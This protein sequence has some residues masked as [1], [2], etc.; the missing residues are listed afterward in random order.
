LRWTAPGLRIP[1]AASGLDGLIPVTIAAVQE[2]D[3]KVESE[4]AELRSE[5]AGL[6]EEN[7]ELKARLDRLE[8]MLLKGK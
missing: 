3:H 8:Q 1:P 6:R 4:T 5:V 2:L 7:A